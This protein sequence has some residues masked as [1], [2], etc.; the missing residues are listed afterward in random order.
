M[1]V[2]SAGNGRVFGEPFRAFDSL[3]FAIVPLSQAAY[4]HF[5]QEQPAGL[6]RAFWEP[7]PPISNV[8]GG[9]GLV[10]ASHPFQRTVRL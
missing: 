3:V 9:Y 1:G 10:W 5:T 2:V 7:Q 4:A 6:D 8:E